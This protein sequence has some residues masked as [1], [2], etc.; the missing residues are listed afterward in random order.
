MPTDHGL[1][2]TSVH[3][4]LIDCYEEDRALMSSQDLAHDAIA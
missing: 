1:N 4:V 3:S 2:L